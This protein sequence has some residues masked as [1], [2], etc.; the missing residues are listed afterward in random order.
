[1]EQAWPS[2][3]VVIIHWNK[4]SLLEQFLPS[5]LESTYPNLEIYLADNA[6]T[7]DSVA[8]VKQYHSKVKVIQLPENK[9]YAGGYNA[10]LKQVKADYY[11]LLNNDVE[12][13]PHWI[14]PVISC[15]EQHPRWAA[16]QP[17]V[18]QYRDKTL[19]EYAGAAGGCMDPLGYVF[20][21]GRLFESLEKDEGQYNDAREV[22]WASGACLFIRSK[23][24]HESGGFD[25]D[26]FAHMEE[27]DLCWRL[28]LMGYHIG[29]CAD[30]SVYH[31]GGSTLQKAHPQKTYLNFRNSLQ[32]IL[33]NAPLSVLW[34]LIPVRSTLDLL[35]SFFF[36]ANGQRPHSWAIHRAHADF[37]FKFGKWWKARK[38]VVRKVSPDQLKGV[39]KGSVVYEHFLL[40]RP[41]FTSL[42]NLSESGM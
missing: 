5:V 9:G 1:M 12:V 15:M 34:W 27:I 41:H 17:K 39:Y 7:D 26:F 6:S 18:L 37:F 22:F 11:I 31:L 23:A 20:C 24:F 16:A 2:V 35:S 14:E 33:K 13:P 4:R 10:A 32:M 30:A 42:G 36:I 40:Q 28:Q 38:N 25:E 29:Y 3:A 8:W 21:R 19:F